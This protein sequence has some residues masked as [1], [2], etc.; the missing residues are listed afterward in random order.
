VAEK[1][2]GVESSSYLYI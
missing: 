2:V 1:V